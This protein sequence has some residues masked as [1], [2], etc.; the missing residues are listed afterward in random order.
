[1][2]WPSLLSGFCGW[3]AV[4]LCGWRVLVVS[5]CH[6]LRVDCGVIVLCLIFLCVV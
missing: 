2:V 5:F 6:R 4:F 1:M 3:F